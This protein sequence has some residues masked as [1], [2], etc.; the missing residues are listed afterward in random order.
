MCGVWWTLSCAGFFR[1]GIFTIPK[2]SESFVSFSHASKKCFNLPTIDKFVT[3][4][5]ENKLFT[6]GW[7]FL[8][9]SIGI[10]GGKDML[11]VSFMFIFTL[12]FTAASSS[13]WAVISIEC[14]LPWFPIPFVEE[15]FRILLSRTPPRCLW[16]GVPKGF[17]FFLSFSTNISMVF[18]CFSW[19]L[20][21]FAKLFDKQIFVMPWQQICLLPHHFF[22]LFRW[23]VEDCQNVIPS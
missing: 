19:S 23:T 1:K 16:R 2:I 6:Y 3:I 14:F 13:C 21:I 20:K 5:S 10:I 4:L 8:R 7:Q 18:F 11:N 12:E 9:S 15:E 17:C 22:G